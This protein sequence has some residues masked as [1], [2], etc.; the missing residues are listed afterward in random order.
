MTARPLWQS[1]DGKLR[2]PQ[3]R[4]RWCS[5]RRRSL[6]AAPAKLLLPLLPLLRHALQQASLHQMPHREADWTLQQ[7][8]LADAFWAVDGLVTSPNGV[9]LLLESPPL[10]QHVIHAL[11][12][13]SESCC[14]AAECWGGA[15]AVA[16]IQAAGDGSGCAGTLAGGSEAT[17]ARVSEVDLSTGLRNACCRVCSLKK[18]HVQQQRAQERQRS[19]LPLHPAL[20]VVGQ[21]AAG[22]TR[23]TQQLLACCCCLRCLEASHAP[24][25]AA[26]DPCSNA[27]SLSLSKRRFLPRASDRPCC[28]RGIPVVLR[29]LRTL[30]LQTDRPSLCREACWA[31]SNLAVG[32]SQQLQLLLQSN[33]LRHA[34]LMLQEQPHVGP[35]LRKEALWLVSNACATAES[36]QQILPLLQHGALQQLWA[37]LEIAAATAD[38]RAAEA[39]LSALG[40]I[41]QLEALLLLQQVYEQHLTATA[42]RKSDELA[43]KLLQLRDSTHHAVPFGSKNHHLFVN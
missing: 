22:S 28:A 43:C 9:S 30:L 6:R 27:D 4:R 26:E 38:G 18:Q 16:L 23:Q 37:L 40:N 20:R 5:D 36:L 35:E 25:V 1:A 13:S 8:T 3:G 39:A 32:S 42:D 33:I 10:L 41:V 2:K 7:E 24:S 11:A 21:V 12:H 31:L 15:E 34:L 19:L 14:C 29:C 17:T